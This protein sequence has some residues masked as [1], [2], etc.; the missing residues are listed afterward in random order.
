MFLCFFNNVPALCLVIQAFSGKCSQER[1]FFAVGEGG[2]SRDNLWGWVFK[3]I[4]GIQET[5]L[6]QKLRI[7]SSFSSDEDENAL[8]HIYSL[9][10]MTPCTEIYK[11]NCVRPCV[12]CS[13]SCNNNNLL[14]SQHPR[15][16]CP[17]ILHFRRHR[18]PG[19]QHVSGKKH[20][21]SDRK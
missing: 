2:D 4:S 16:F 20:K 8:H 6:H 1:F 3:G 14:W 15:C 10:R 21:F 13:H 12:I 17:V 11:F 18:N 7:G 19:Q 9:L 5:N